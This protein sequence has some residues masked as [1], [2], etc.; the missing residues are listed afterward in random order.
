MFGK[1]VITTVSLKKSQESEIPPILG[2][3][4][5]SLYDKVEGYDKGMGQIRL[6][7]RGLL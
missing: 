5:G 2:A 1:V 3:A 6:I 7:T 4:R